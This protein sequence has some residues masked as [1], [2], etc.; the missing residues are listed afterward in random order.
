MRSARLATR[1]DTAAVDRRR[2][3]RL[4]GRP[5]R[6]AA[7]R[8]R[9]AAPAQSTGRGTWRGDSRDAPRTLPDRF[10]G[11]AARDLALSDRRSAVRVVRGPRPGRSTTAVV[12]SAPPEL[13]RRT[14][15]AGIPAR[16]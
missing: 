6:P 16:A 7:G 12:H 1:A 11:G 15:G 8:G 2:R 4:A 9:S 14:G 10:A 5:L 13:L 3:H